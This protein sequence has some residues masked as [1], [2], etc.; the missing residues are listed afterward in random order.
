MAKFLE[1]FFRKA[2][3]EAHA[4]G[5][6]GS[7]GVFSR[8]ASF[9]TDND[10]LPDVLDFNRLTEEGFR[11][12]AIVHACI[13]RISRSV[14]EPQLKAVTVLPGGELETN[15]HNTGDPLADILYAPNP[16]QDQ[17]EL[18]EQLLIHLM[19]AGNAFIYKVRS[20]S[21]A[22]VQLE[23]IRPDLMGLVIGKNR[24]EGRVK[25][26]TV[27]VGDT[28]KRVPIDKRDII[29]IK[30]PDALDEYWG[31]SPLYTIA[32][33]GD[34][35]TQ[36]INF[37]RAYFKNRGIPS[38]LLT[39]DKPVAKVERDRVRDLW[40]EQFQGLEGWHNAA[41]LDA[42]VSYTPLATGIERMDMSAITSQ[43]ETRICMVYGIPPVLVGGQFG[44]GKST[45]SNLDAS[46]KIFWT[47]TLS[48]MFAR[49]SR[50]LTRNL[51]QEE[52]GQDRQAIF[53]LSTVAALTENK[54]E[55]RKIALQ[56]WNLGLLTRNQ[57]NKMLGLAQ[58]ETQG[59]VVK[60][61]PGTIFLPLGDVP[62]AVE[63]VVPTAQ[64]PDV[65]PADPTKA[66]K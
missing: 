1:K 36:S 9:F 19:V 40:K 33:Y 7:A 17:Y 55:I 35:D 59:D 42:N 53:D 25:N 61:V 46:E 28:Q 26:Y 48:P 62:N 49:I 18:F 34:L 65:N 29:H 20:K 60:I 4:F 21:G 41:V 13:R 12:N 15:A 8:F 38:G 10:S 23:L 14:A 43:S 24:E 44:L 63:A 50:K 30:M 31:L 66:T 58:S 11:R 16:D 45:F 54:S 5:E 3:K 32:Q 51:A 6:Y 22:V 56:G 39:F 37:L 2:P 52:F 57:S 64:A 47:D 27:K